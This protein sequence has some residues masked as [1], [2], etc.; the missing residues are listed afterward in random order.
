[1]HGAAW[2]T[3]RRAK[4]ALADEDGL[5]ALAVRLREDLAVA[6]R[7]EDREGSDIKLTMDN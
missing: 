6:A 7:Q 1:M 3:A 2:A 4:T 5:A